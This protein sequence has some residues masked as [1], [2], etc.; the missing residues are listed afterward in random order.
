[1]SVVMTQ[2]DTTRPTE[3]CVD[4]DLRLPASRQTPSALSALSELF[5]SGTGLLAGRGV[6]CFHKGVSS[7]QAPTEM[8]RAF[9]PAGAPARQHR[10]NGRCASARRH[11]RK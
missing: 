1:M 10:A 11:D 2:A 7:R 5:L 3:E 4:H 8:D 9:V 6:T